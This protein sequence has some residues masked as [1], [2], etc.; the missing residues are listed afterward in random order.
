MTDQPTE[1]ADGVEPMT[2]AEL[3]IGYRDYPG[4]PPDWER[5]RAAL[6]HREKLMA[7]NAAREEKRAR[8]HRPSRETLDGTRI[9]EGTG[10]WA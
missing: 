6:V 4:S 9:H 8:V 5:I 2:V 1:T 3:G 7:E 10:G